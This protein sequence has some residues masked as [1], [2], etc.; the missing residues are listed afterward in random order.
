[1]C[2]DIAIKVEN[3]NKCYHIYDKPHDRLKQMLM[4]GRRQ[5]FQEFWALRDVSFE[6]KKGET[7]G[8][9]G[10]NG[11]GKSTL[12]QMICGTLN[13]TSG[14]IQTQGR[15]AALLELGAGFNPEFT[16]RENVYMNGAI[17]GLT[18][19]QVDAR[20]EEIA[21]FADIGNFI[22]QPVKTYSSGM[23]VRLAFASNIMSRPE[24]MIV[25]E[26]LSVGDMNFQAKC[27]TALTRIQDNG[28]TI[29]FV[30]HDVGSVKSLCSR[31]VYLERGQV[32]TVGPAAEVAERYIRTMR[33]EMNEE[34]RKFSR[35]SAA[36]GEKPARSVDQVM[37]VDEPG[38][39][40]SAEFDKRVAQFR[41]GSGEVKVASVELLDS[42]GEDLT[43]VEFNQDVKVK[44]YFE[45]F[46]E[47][48][49]SVNFS[50]FDEKK[51]NIVG[52]GFPH[53]D[54]PYL[55]TRNN[56][57]YLAEYSLKLPLQ[58]GIY[59]LRIN[60]SSPIVEN[61]SAEFVDFVSDAVVFKVGRWDKSRVWS[62]VHVF[63]EL[64]LQEFEV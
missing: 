30:S 44:V 11:S 23:F 43:F 53:A 47:K 59:S 5:Y 58:E 29:L 24:I 37:T 18:E 31:G 51:N 12:L 32:I 62:K 45:A 14:S 16:G 46:A 21:S 36:F 8:I 1:M 28:A 26:A 64:K 60:I 13:P 22:E 55:V 49:I 19:D 35:V 57:K 61:E 15:I 3:L 52:C 50:V 2:S 33:E 39:K 17:L 25:D 20:F 56:G 38:F 9:I 42:K 34:H 63:S 4:R 41:Y 54:Q 7:V 6:I 27:M 48:S 10:R 40:R